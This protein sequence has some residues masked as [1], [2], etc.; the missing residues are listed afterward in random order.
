MGMATI[1]TPTR[2]RYE[3]A[4][5]VRARKLIFLTDTPGVLRDTNDPKSVIPTIFEDEIEEMIEKKTVS[6]GMIPKLRSARYALE[7][8][9]KVHILDGRVPHSLLLELFTPQGIGTQILRREN[10]WQSDK[11]KLS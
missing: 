8:C 9:R 6:G 1:S 7:I 5:A 11:L 3:I 10:T 2:W 4:R